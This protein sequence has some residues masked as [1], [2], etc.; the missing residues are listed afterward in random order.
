[1]IRRTLPATKAA[2]FSV[3]T[4]DIGNQDM[5]TPIGSGFFIHETGLFLTAD[6][7]IGTHDPHELLLTQHI[8][9]MLGSG[10]QYMWPELVARWPQHDLALLKFD[11]S[12]GP[13]LM[14]TGRDRPATLSLDSALAE[15]GSPVYAFGYPLSITSQAVEM[16]STAGEAWGANI[17]LHPRAVSAVVSSTVEGTP[18]PGADQGPA[19]YVVDNRLDHGI[20]GSPLVLQETGLVIGVCAHYQGARF[21]QSVHGYD[22][23]IVIPSAYGVAVSVAN[24]AS[25]LA[26][27][28]VR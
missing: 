7:V 14:L 9:G 5:P 2:T 28:G 16:E 13:S 22:H 27:L 17:N 26:D 3:A 25:D 24:V 6:H 8:P 23:P 4:G 12:T 11:H 21:S 18:P 15:D 1:M 10:F 19:V 20:S